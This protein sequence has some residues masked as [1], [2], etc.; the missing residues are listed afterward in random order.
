M[1]FYL[2][3]LPNLL[4]YNYLCAIRMAPRGTSPLLSC[5]IKKAIR[6]FYTVII[7]IG[8]TRLIKQKR[9]LILNPIGMQGVIKLIPKGA[10]DKLE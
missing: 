4:I 2:P 6:K 9:H 10:F 8:I 3:P 7:C 5:A 1:G